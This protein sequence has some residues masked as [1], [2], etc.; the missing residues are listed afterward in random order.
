MKN[1]KGRNLRALQPQGKT[2]QNIH[3]KTWD[4]WQPQRH[5]FSVSC[6]NVKI[7]FSS[8]YFLSIYC[9]YVTHFSDMFDVRMDNYSYFR[10]FGVE[11]TV[12][13]IKKNESLKWNRLA[14]FV[15]KC[16]LIMNMRFGLVIQANLSI[17][18]LDPSSFILTCP[19]PHWFVFI[20]ISSS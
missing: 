20:E 8:C 16:S 10:D 5:T 4:L 3:L 13:Q 1:C 9:N 17:L 7:C 15:R 6:I 14:I 19:M 11:C 2:F 12:S 18:S